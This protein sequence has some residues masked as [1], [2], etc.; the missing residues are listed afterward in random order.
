MFERMYVAQ[1]EIGKFFGFKLAHWLLSFPML[2]NGLI[3]VFQ[4]YY[5][6]KGT[7]NIRHLEAS[8]AFFNDEIFIQYLYLYNDAEVKQ[9]RGTH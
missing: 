3:S 4:S 2:F 6:N 9:D 5:I 1:I 8:W 7:T